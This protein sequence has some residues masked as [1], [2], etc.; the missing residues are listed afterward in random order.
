MDTHSKQP[1]KILIV[2]D[3]QNLRFVLAE[4]AR[5][6]HFMPE[7]ASNGIE[8]LAHLSKFPN[9]ID[10]IITDLRMPEMD[11]KSLVQNCRAQ[12]FL[13][14]IIVLTAFGTVND[15]VDCMKAGANDF[16]TK[17]IDF[18]E[19][20]LKLNENRTKESNTHVPPQIFVAPGTFKDVVKEQTQNI[21]RELIGRVLMENDWNVTHTADRLGISRKGLQLKMKELGLRERS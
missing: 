18:N 10:I 9:Q 4:M 3:D 13:G 7:Q 19:L 1:S 2:E 8:A 16:L 14:Q 17:P 11:G 6:L 20:R 15:A 5:Q 12:G 21:E